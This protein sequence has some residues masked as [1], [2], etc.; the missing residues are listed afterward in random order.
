MKSHDELSSLGECI[1]LDAL[2]LGVTN[3]VDLDRD[4]ATMRSRIKN[5]G[6]SFITITLPNFMQGIERSLEEGMVTH[7]NFH[8]WKF[9]KCLPAF[10]RGFT[11]L[12]F[13]V[14]TGHVL[15][16]PD[17]LS[18]KCLRQFCLMFKKIEFPCTPK[19]V[20]RAVKGYKDVEQLLSSGH[21]PDTVATFI[22]ISHLIWGNMF[23]DFNS[24][25]TIPKHGPGS[26]EERIMYNQKYVHR[27][28]HERLQPFFPLD[29]FA[30]VNINQVDDPIYGLDSVRM[31]PIGEERPVRVITVPKTQKAPRIIA[32]EPVCMQYAQQALARYIISKL[33]NSGLT[34]GHINF[35]DQSVNQNLAIDSSVSR[36]FA[37]LDMSEASDRVPLSLVKLML[38]GCPLLKDALLACRSLEARTPD[39]ETIRLMKFASMGSAVCFPI[40]AMYFFTVVLTSLV[41]EHQL[42]VTLRNLKAL[43]RKVYVYGDDIFV[44]TGVVTAVT[45]TLA[46]YYCKVNSHKSFWNSNFRE[47]CGMDAFRGQSITP[48]YIRRV[49]PSNRADTSRILSSIATCNQFYLNGYWRTASFMKDHIE[50]VVGKLPIVEE[51]CAGVGWLSYQKCEFR[52]R[53]Y[54]KRRTNRELQRSE[55]RTL[56]P[57]VRTKP[58]EI[59]SWPALMKCLLRSSGGEQSESYLTVTPKVSLT[60]R[61][62]PLDDSCLEIRRANHLMRSP[63]PGNVALNRRWTT[64]Y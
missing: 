10:L 47:S 34:R 1:L 7:R 5:E 31:V 25:D 53:F 52:N 39:G 56:V 2:A 40:E 45:E 60:G 12:I 44:P 20:M 43:S 27:I 24:F 21:V 36:D 4:L 61:Q 23:E 38:S 42:P 28:W 18:I 14:A 15:P 16:D 51:T 13:D 22:E 62:L 29:S 54:R 55:I 26:T 19:R 58:D 50:A 11:S 3:Q 64:E 41:V 9:S 30:M 32:I 6:L 33:E 49:L 17:V 63:R 59:D 35:R 48:V 37:S 46:D 57:S 8:G